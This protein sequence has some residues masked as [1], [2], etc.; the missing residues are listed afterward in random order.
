MLVELSDKAFFEQPISSESD[1]ATSL[2][3]DIA[4]SIPQAVA[5]ITEITALLQH[6]T[7]RISI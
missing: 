1:L 4:F 2:A 5:I 3:E 6:N 7:L